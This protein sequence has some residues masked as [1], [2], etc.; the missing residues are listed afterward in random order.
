MS[1][2]PADYTEAGVLWHTDHATLVSVAT[3]A[4]DTG[5]LS[6]ASDVLAFFEKPWHFPELWHTYQ[7]SSP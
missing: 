1:T 3:L 5:E 7:E 4:I 6:T 2:T